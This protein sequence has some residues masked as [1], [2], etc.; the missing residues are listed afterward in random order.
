[1]FYQL[2]GS[3]LVVKNKTWIKCEELCK[4]EKNREP[5]VVLWQEEEQK[6]KNADLNSMC[7]K[8]QQQ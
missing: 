7:A 4:L 3:L 5:E 1:M 8:E 6:K 2:Q